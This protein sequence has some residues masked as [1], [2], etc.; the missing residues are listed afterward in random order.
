LLVCCAH[1]ELVLT[2]SCIPFQWIQH[3]L[4]VLITRIIGFL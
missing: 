2:L 4:S 1:C 3:L